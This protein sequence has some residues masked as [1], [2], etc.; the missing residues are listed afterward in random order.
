MYHDWKK[1]KGLLVDF[2]QNNKLSLNALEYV[3]NHGILSNPNKRDN[4]NIINPHNTFSIKPLY[5]LIQNLL[6]KMSSPDFTQ[7]I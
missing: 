1:N 5:S 4:S 2:I 3:R 7:R 6:P